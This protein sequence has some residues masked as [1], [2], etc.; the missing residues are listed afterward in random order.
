[1]SVSIIFEKRADKYDLITI[2]SGLHK[3]TLQNLKA[4]ASEFRYRNYSVS[5]ADFSTESRLIIR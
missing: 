3:Q 5:I 2:E 1:M 4:I